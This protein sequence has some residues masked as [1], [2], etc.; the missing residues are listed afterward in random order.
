MSSRSFLPRSVIVGTV[1][2]DPDDG[3]EPDA[4]YTFANER[5]FLAW[6]RT[7]LAI[8]VFTHPAPLR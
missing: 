8:A 7:A 4:R 1:N 6:S 3:T 5:T 2:S